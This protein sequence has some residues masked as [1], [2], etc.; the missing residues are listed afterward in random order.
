MDFFPVEIFSFL[1]FLKTISLRANLPFFKKQ[2]YLRMSQNI[3][4]LQRPP[5]KTS[6]SLK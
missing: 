3:V 1:R 6:K 5:E 4:H 2:L